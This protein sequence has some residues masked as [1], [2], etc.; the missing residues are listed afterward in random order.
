MGA[1]TSEYRAHQ[2]SV[3]LQ[4]CSQDQASQAETRPV[5]STKTMTGI[6]EH[7]HETI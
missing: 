7:Q 6:K 2:N 3:I 1:L 5:K 4:S